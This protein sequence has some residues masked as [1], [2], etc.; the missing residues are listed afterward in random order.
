[1]NTINFLVVKVRRKDIAKEIAASTAESFSAPVIHASVE[2]EMGNIL[3]SSKNVQCI[4]L[5]RNYLIIVIDFTNANFI[6]Y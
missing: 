3:V 4:R 1:V 2:S 5:I 6:S